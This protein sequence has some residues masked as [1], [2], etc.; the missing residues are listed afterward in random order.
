VA[1]AIAARA[2]RPAIGADTAA[3]LSAELPRLAPLD[4][5]AAR[6][7]LRIAPGFRIDLVASEELLSSPVAIAW[8]EDGRLFVAEMRGYS[9]HRDEKLSR[10]RL[11]TDTDDDG[12]YDRAQVFAD[13]LAWP[14]ALCCYDGGL[15]VGDAPDI[16]YLEDAD[17]DGTAEVR[18]RV[19]TGFGTGNVQGLFNSFTFAFDNR[20]HGSASAVGGSVRR[21]DDADAA[22]VDLA[23]CDF[24]FDPRSLSLRPETGG[25]QH[26]LSFDDAGG[27]YVCANSDQANRCMIESRLLGRNRFFTPPPVTVNVAA[28]GPQGEVFRASPPEAWRVLR[29][30]LRAAGL[31]PGP[32][33]HGGRITGYF[34]SATGITVVRG[35]AFGPELAGMLVIGD[36]G[37]NL[38]H[39][40]RVVADG[41]G[42]RAE[43]VDVGSE[44][45][46]AADN[47]FRPVQF[48]NGPDGALWIIDMQREVIEH[49]NSLPPEIKRHIDLD[50]GRD[51][52]RL[53][54]LA[55]EDFR[56]RPTPR[57]S[58]AT[59]AELVRL[60]G[61]PNAWHRETAQR[62][63]FERRDPEAVPLLER[64]AVDPAADPR[65]RRLAL[66][67]LDAAGALAPAQLLAALEADDPRLRAAAVRLTEGP[68][69]A[70]SADGA[71]AD[72]L[73]A[74][75]KAEPDAAVRMQLALAAGWLDTERRVAVVSEILRRD[76]A[77]VWCRV[78]AFTSLDGEA[79]R[80]LAAALADP[81]LVAPAG[82][83]ETLAG[84]ASQVA[85]EGDPAEL[86]AVITAAGT[87]A[88]KA[89]GSEAAGGVDPPSMA[90]AVLL[91]L[92]RSG[93]AAGR[94][95]DAALATDAARAAVG[96]LFA[97]NAGRA[98][99]AA[100]PLAVRQAA[101]RGLAIAPLADAAGTFARVLEH[102]QPPE[103]VAEA[104]ATLDLSR[105]A[106]VADVLLAAWPGLG[107]EP[108]RAAG[109]ALARNPHRATA[110]LDAVAAGTVREADLLRSTVINL[111][112]FPV[113][114][115]RD[116]ATGVFGELPAVRRDELVEAYRPSLAATG[117]VA[118]GKSLFTRHCATC[119]RVG[120]VGREIGPNLVAMQARGAEAILMGVL[121]PN[122]EVQPQYVAHVAVTGD[123]RV[124]TGVIAAESPT[125]VTLRTADG[126]QTTLS[127]DDIEE[128][129][130]T[131]K[132]LMPEGF[133]REIDIRGMGD[134]LSWLMTAR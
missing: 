114:A 38:V 62:L 29:T 108:R 22:P 44:L 47:W 116:R 68:I 101:V 80:I 99:D 88:S 26:G 73:V 6:K 72:R 64:L 131:K 93:E 43:R 15:F 30:R 111:Q 133:E 118:A 3:D 113:A 18:R 7:S 8:D 100:Q 45:V 54:R 48:A 23:G 84:L 90:T 97:W 46:A 27:K 11:L 94:K 83:A 130:S 95:V 70:G 19:F 51:R 16:L 14:T 117:D 34:T 92:V 53:W 78:A 121:D 42:V 127:R 71:L 128:L 24:S 5:E 134:L 66:H 21:V 123:G 67:A 112:A 96:R 122:R 102:G 119:H 115:V 31:A 86:A 17:G 33:E 75:T 56:R 125:S 13:G 61:H 25:R 20:I 132:S 60:L 98:L 55:P 74:L 2:D 1:L 12:V 81:A 107:A 69:R 77:D 52:G 76:A 37:S 36:V 124:V 109:A 106:E 79:G 39:R 28:D 82:A 87:L 110:L 49:P 9:E 89:S 10:I 63:L 91:G 105:D 50:S 35:D 126:T 104:V 85:L 4:A 32:I 129:E 103:V 41:A 120:D 57:L 59:T 58:R 65:G 40:K